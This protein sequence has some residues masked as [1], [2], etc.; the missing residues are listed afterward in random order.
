MVAAYKEH[1]WGRVAYDREMQLARKRYQKAIDAGFDVPLAYSKPY[2]SLQIKRAITYSKGA[3]FLDVL[4]SHV[5]DK[6]FW[7][8]IRN[9][10]RK[11]AGKTVESRGLQN[12]L[13]KA[14]GKDLTAFFKKW[15]YE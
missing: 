6:S 7:L 11:H 2:P 8:G 1:Q 12:E 15:V 10:T 13:E 14:S 9:Y 5:G 4:R 3:L